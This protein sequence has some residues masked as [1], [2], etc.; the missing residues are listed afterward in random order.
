MAFK[1]MDPETRQKLFDDHEMDGNMP[2]EDMGIQGFDP[3]TVAT[4]DLT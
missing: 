2:P 4:L 1:Y 3:N